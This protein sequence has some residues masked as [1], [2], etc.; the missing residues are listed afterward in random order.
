MIGTL[1]FGIG[2]YIAHLFPHLSPTYDITVLSYSHGSSGDTFVMDDTLINTYVSNFSL[3]LNPHGMREAHDSIQALF[4]THA[5][6]PFDL[7]NVHIS[8]YTRK[9]AHIL[10]PF[11]EHLR[12][13]RIP[14]VFTF[15]D[16]LPNPEGGKITEYLKYFYSLC[17]HAIVGN[18]GEE[19][20]LKDTL[21]IKRPTSIAT[22]GIYSLF[23]SGTVTRDDARMALKIPDDKVVALFFGI[24]REDKG[25]DD[26]IHAY[27]FLHDQHLL[28]IAVSERM[29]TRFESFQRMIATLGIEDKIKVIVKPEASTAEIETYFTASDIV[30]LPY[31]NTSQSGILNLAF[32]FEKP[33]LVTPV[34]AESSAIDGRMGYVVEKKNPHLLAQTLADYANKKHEVLPVF[35]TSIRTY[36]EKH[37]FAQTADIYRSVFTSLLKRS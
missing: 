30:A 1:K 31:H 26:L 33:S 19:R 7:C 4:H 28:L 6:N 32:A 10:I 18:G 15:H 36:N 8:S 25:L 2:H 34:F 16:V 21:F 27:Q 3:C 12:R 37:S 13:Q 17:D 24:L 5:E 22:H 29:G 20:H 35:T 23:R 9:S 11:L 14:M